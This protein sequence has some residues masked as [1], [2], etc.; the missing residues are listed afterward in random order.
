MLLWFWCLQWQPCALFCLDRMFCNHCHSPTLTEPGQQY[1]Q[2]LSAPRGCEQRLQTGHA[3][4]CSL[5]AHSPLPCREPEG[6]QRS[7]ARKGTV[8]CWGRK[9]SGNGKSRLSPCA[10]ELQCRV[11]GLWEQ[12]FFLLSQWH[13]IGREAEILLIAFS[14]SSIVSGKLQYLFFF[15]NWSHERMKC[16]SA[17]RGVLAQWF[18]VLFFCWGFWVETLPSFWFVFTDFKCI[19]N[20]FALLKCCFVKS[21][22]IVTTATEIYSS[23]AQHCKEVVFPLQPLPT[24]EVNILLCFLFG[25][26]LHCLPAAPAGAGNTDVQRDHLNHSIWGLKKDEKGIMWCLFLSSLCRGLQLGLLLC[27]TVN[28]G[29]SRVP[30]TPSSPL[31]LNTI[32]HPVWHRNVLQV[33]KENNQVNWKLNINS[34]W[35]MTQHKPQRTTGILNQWYPFNNQFPA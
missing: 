31:F 7:S 21:L 12:Q 17:L 3:S 2:G 25:D 35:Y 22:E 33:H 28:G 16:F 10:P 32:W 18:S 14:E 19:V 26:V 23:V 9:Y 13:Q 30:H 24:E 8:L 29:E 1:L 34:I 20:K 5:I 4:L 11:K 27:L 6:L 15:L